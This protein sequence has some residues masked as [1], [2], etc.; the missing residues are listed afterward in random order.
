MQWVSFGIITSQGMGTILFLEKLEINKEE[1]IL[2]EGN[3]MSEVQGWIQN[4]IRSMTCLSAHV[5]AIFCKSGLVVSV[6]AGSC[7]YSIP[8][9]QAE[10]YT[11]VE[12]GINLNI[13]EWDKYL[14]R[15]DY[16]LCVYAY[17][18]IELVDKLISD[19]GGIDQQY[20]KNAPKGS[21]KAIYNKIKSA[22][23]EIYIAYRNKKADNYL[24]LFLQQQKKEAKVNMYYKPRYGHIRMNRQAKRR[25]KRKWITS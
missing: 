4:R 18:P 9:K 17:V 22:P 5:I 14:D 19:N 13:P 21:R 7:N 24:Y 2:K 12:V 23:S 1:N 15:E 11:E 10:K 16:D 25:M 6:Q 3:K 8:R 20:M